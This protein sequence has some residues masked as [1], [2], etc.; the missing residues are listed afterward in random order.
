MITGGATKVKDGVSGKDGHPG[1]G[2][3]SHERPNRG[4]PDRAARP[5]DFVP[6][7]VGHAT[8]VPEASKK[9]LTAGVPVEAPPDDLDSLALDA[10]LLACI[11]AR[12]EP[13]R[14]AAIE[15]KLASLLRRRGNKPAFAAIGRRLEALKRRRRRGQLAGL[16]L[17]ARL[18]ELAREVAE[19]EKGVSPR[20]AQEE[21]KAALSKLFKEVRGDLPPA[22]VKRIVN[23]IDR[24]T[25]LI[26]FRGWQQSFDGEHVVIKSL[27]MVLRKYDLNHEHKLF[28]RVYEYIKEILL[29]FPGPTLKAVRR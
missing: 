7:V 28:D 3:Q 25:R 8:S 18:L 10:E 9:K 24:D 26:R 1:V 2:G 13:E 4:G 15:S 27:R 23:E 21:D 14:L 11:L 6:A 12:N 22:W 16:E 17:L 29:R 5:G 19:A 20:E